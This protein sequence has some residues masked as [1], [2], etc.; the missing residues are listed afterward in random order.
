M[1]SSLSEWSLKVYC[2]CGKEEENTSGTFYSYILYDDK[3]NIIYAVC[4]HGFV[5]INKEREL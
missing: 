5:I 1:G 3:G 4:I 2:P